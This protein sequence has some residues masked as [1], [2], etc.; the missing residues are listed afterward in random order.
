MIYFKINP[1][2][3]KTSLRPSAEGWFC[4]LRWNKRNASILFCWINLLLEEK[5]WINLLSTHVRRTTFQTKTNVQQS[6]TS[7]GF[8]YEKSGLHIIISFYVLTYICTSSIDVQLYISKYSPKT[9]LRTWIRLSRRLWSVTQR[10]HIFS[11]NTF[12]RNLNSPR[13]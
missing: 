3:H 12:A 13:I 1:L 6:V 7:F 11:G 5:E 8:F 10:G 9:P 4:V 2:G